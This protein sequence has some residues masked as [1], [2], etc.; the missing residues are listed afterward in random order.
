MMCKFNTSSSS[1]E[2][3]VTWVNVVLSHSRS[4]VCDKEHNIYSI[5]LF[6]NPSTGRADRINPMFQQWDITYTINV[7]WCCPSCLG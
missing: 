4:E 3:C 5:F 1:I 7:D 6:I 2:C